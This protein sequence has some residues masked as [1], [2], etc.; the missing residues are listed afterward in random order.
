MLLMAATTEAGLAFQVSSIT[1][2][3]PSAHVAGKISPLWREGRSLLRTSF[4]ALGSSP[5]AYMIE[6]SIVQ[7]IA[8]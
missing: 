7:F 6:I 1:V 4:V 8:A 3:D 2:K 5:K